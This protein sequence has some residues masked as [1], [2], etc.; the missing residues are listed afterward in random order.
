[1]APRSSA[2]RARALEHG[3]I[4][5]ALDERTQIVGPSRWLAL[6]VGVLVLLGLVA[7]AASREIETTVEAGGV[8]IPAGGFATVAA[9]RSGIVLVAPPAEGTLV[10]PGEVVATLDTGDGVTVPV[11][12]LRGGTVE[13]VSAARGGFVTAGDELATLT[14]EAVPTVV[15]FVPT[16]DVAQLRVGLR[17][18]LSPGGTE[19]TVDRIADRPASPQRLRLLLGPSA[20]PYLTGPPVQEVEILPAPAGLRPGTQ[21]TARVIVRATSPIREIF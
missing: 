18:R 12:A 16:S 20:G 3:D 10:R 11:R 21:L 9:P 17:T 5:E 14:P 4:R 1:M 6:V 13:A 2:F 19:G 7:W 8:V 15:V